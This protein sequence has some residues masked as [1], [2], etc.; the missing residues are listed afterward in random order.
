ML[1]PGRED[2]KAVVVGAGAAGLGAAI[3]LAA[4][5]VSFIVLEA[6]NRPGGR[7]FTTPGASYPLDLGCGWLHSADRNP[8]TQIAIKAGFAVD[9][10]LPAWGA[11]SVNLGVSAEDRTAFELASRQFNERLAKINANDADCAAAQ[12]LEPGCRFNPLLNAISSYV[13]GAELDLV[14]VHDT[15]NYADTGINWRV[16]EGYGTLIATQAVPLPIQFDCP[17]S[18][19]DHHGKRLAIETPLG[20]VA[21]DVVIV[22]VPTPII[23]TQKIRFKPELRD[24]IDAASVLPL[25]LADKLF[26]AIDNP[27]ALP[28]EGHV[29]GKFMSAETGS[30]HLRPFGRPLIEAFYGGRLAHELEAGG[31]AAFFDF[32]ATEL[33]ALFGGSIRSHLRP[34]AQ[35]HW[36]LDPFACGSYSYARPGHANARAV[37]A[38]PVGERLF[39]AGEACS[40]HDFTTAHGAFLTGIEAAEGVIALALGKTGN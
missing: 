27:E 32:A 4:G 39:F 19:I 11:Q 28:K 15:N 10:T 26:M 1:S 17:V 18:L 3:H 13:G 16:V 5:R 40:R 29:I 14:S 23:A 12:L 24:K 25:G 8:W 2:F 31:R 38:A 6:R 22:T 21:A 35:S 37:L 30:Y 33:G 34:L 7:A 9:K 36:A 20:T